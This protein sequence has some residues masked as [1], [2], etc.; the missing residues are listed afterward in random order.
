MNRYYIGD[1][2][3]EYYYVH[4]IEDEYETKEIA[5]EDD[6]YGFIQCLKHF[7]FVG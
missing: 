1:K 6:L 7:G 5:K 3:C 4:I 2:I